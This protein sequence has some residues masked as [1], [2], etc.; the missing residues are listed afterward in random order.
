MGSDGSVR[1]YSRGGNV[2][3]EVIYLNQWS[4]IDSSCSDAEMGQEQKNK[5]IRAA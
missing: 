4:M 2:P 3:W 1:T 5:S